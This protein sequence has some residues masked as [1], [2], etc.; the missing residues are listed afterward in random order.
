[1]IPQG[2]V[3]HGPAPTPVVHTP[4]HHARH[5]TYPPILAGKAPHGRI[6]SILCYALT[7][8]VTDGKVERGSHA[9]FIRLKQSNVAQTL[10]A[11]RARYHS[12]T[13]SVAMTNILLTGM[14]AGCSLG[15][16]KFRSAEAARESHHLPPSI[17]R[18][19]SRDPGELADT[20]A[21]NTDEK[22]I[23]S[24]KKWFRRHKFEVALN[25]IEKALKRSLS[26]ASRLEALMIR[27]NIFK[28]QGKFDLAIRDY[29]EILI[30][31]EKNITILNSL[32]ECYLNKRM[33]AE[34]IATADRV[35]EIDDSNGIAWKYCGVANFYEKNYDR[36]LIELWNARKFGVVDYS[37]LTTLGE[38]CCIKE[39][40]TQ[41]I[42]YFEQAHKEYPIDIHVTAR[43]GKLYYLAG[44]ST[45]ALEKFNRAIEM[46]L[47]RSYPSTYRDRGILYFENGKSSSQEAVLQAISD[48]DQYL[49]KRK[50]DQEVI[51]LRRLAIAHL[52]SLVL[53]ALTDAAIKNPR[54]A[55]KYH[56]TE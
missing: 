30:S 12:R 3:V 10:H 33:Y 55:R 14:A 22:V 13:P 46:D 32:A 44:E 9:S 35:L 51:S 47:D 23:D 39:K 54:V 38:I 19:A 16:G 29:Q 28:Q 45:K 43:L 26:S 56:A 48:F 37:L 4:G 34:A 52:G 18:S 49:A 24:A 21:I 25:L 1:M 7:D 2:H 42:S 36:A 40:V 5:S 20:E 6:Q 53:K 17:L 11:R 27:G 41:A 8:E 15:D 50:T 31:D